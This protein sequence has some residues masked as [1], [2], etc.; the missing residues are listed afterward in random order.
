MK[1]K[2]QPESENPNRISMTMEPESVAEGL[3]LSVFLRFDQNVLSVSVN[4]DEKNK[5][6]VLLTLTAGADH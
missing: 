2:F 5:R 1:I 4:R 3:L 6:L